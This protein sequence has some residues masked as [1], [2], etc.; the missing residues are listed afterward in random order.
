MDDKI[1]KVETKVEASPQMLEMQQTIKEMQQ[2]QDELTSRLQISTKTIEDQNTAAKTITD[3]AAQVEADK[4][5][6][7]KDIRA[8]LGVKQTKQPVRSLDDINS[9]T[10]VEMME[11]MAS[12]VETAVDATRQEAELEADKSYKGLEAKFDQIVSHVMKKDADVALQTVRSKYKDFDNH[13]EAI[14]EVLNK[15]GNMTYDE[16]YTFVK[17]NVAKGEIAAKHIVSEKPDGDLST[18]D[19]AIVRVK[20]EPVGRKISN[21]RQFKNALDA[22]VDKV[23]ANR[24]GGN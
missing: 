7:E 3:N 23:M 16:A 13:T 10:N 2:T 4:L 19:E 5:T 6:I 15:F 17:A 8:S 1:T 12:A 20:K 11:V 21:R 9:L 22:A 14:R 18:A 24:S